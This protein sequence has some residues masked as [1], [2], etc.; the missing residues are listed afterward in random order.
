MGNVDEFWQDAQ[1]CEAIA[2]YLNDALGLHPPLR[3]SGSPP[4]I[5]TYLPHQ[6]LTRIGKLLPQIESALKAL[7]GPKYWELHVYVD[8]EGTPPRCVYHTLLEKSVLAGADAIS[9]PTNLGKL[10]HLV[11]SN[12]RLQ[13]QVALKHQTARRRQSL[14]GVTVLTL[15]SFAVGIATPLFDRRVP[16]PSS[17]PST[18]VLAPE[19]APLPLP[20]PVLSEAAISGEE[21]LPSPAEKAAQGLPQLPSAAYA[22]AQPPTP[23]TREIIKPAVPQ[24]PTESIAVQIKAV[25]DI[26]PGS[27]F[28]GYRLPEDP[29]YLFNSVKMYLGEVD[30]L[31]GNF[32]STFTEIPYSAKDTSRGMTFAFRTPPAFADVLRSAGFHVLSVANNH[33]FDFGDQGF[34]DTIAHIERS[35]MRAVGRKG[36]IVTVDANGYAVAFIGFSYWP[37][38]ND[39]N[40]LVT[41]TNLVKTAASQAD[42]VVISVHAGAEGTDALRVR[43]QTE[44]FF[45]ENRGNMVQFS[46]AMIDAGADLILG[47]G[48]HVPRAI[49]LYQGKLIAYSL[50]NFLGYET[51]QTTGPLGQSLILQVDLNE[52]GDFLQGRIIP[53]ALDDNGVPYI[54]DLFTSVS[55][56]NRLTV[57]DFPNTP[58]TINSVGHILRTDP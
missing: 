38:H 29:N 44:Y 51:L 37:D 10:P 23:E 16:S 28:E 4:S 31:F 8:G 39:M 33:S 7:P 42:I 15:A 9:P 20:D 21:T 55:L 36:E 49:E 5:N 12:T 3:V 26:I 25:G 53:V 41:G 57:Q 48:P 35:G 27:D 11:T 47:H 2:R 34:A 24:S 58:L 19:F 54:D 13:R 14:V 22:Q 52:V 43:N 50:G 1:P 17:G 18:D 45:S 6:Y 46:R 56:I 30:I 40:D 32:E